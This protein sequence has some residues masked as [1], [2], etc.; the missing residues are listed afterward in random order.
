[1]MFASGSLTV[2][3]ESISGLGSAPSVV[4]TGNSPVE[5][6]QTGLNFGLVA[7]VGLALAAA[8]AVTAV[9]RIRD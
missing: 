4:N 9:A 2:L 6:A 7:I 5:A 8:V 1:M 3:T